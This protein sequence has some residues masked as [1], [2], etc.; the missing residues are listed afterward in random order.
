MYN[1]LQ[2][3]KQHIK[4]YNVKLLEINYFLIHDLKKQSYH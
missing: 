3:D 1:L 2:V 4:S